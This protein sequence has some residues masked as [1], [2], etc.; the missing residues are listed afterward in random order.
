MV[1]KVL[2]SSPSQ[3]SKN[4]QRQGIPCAEVVHDT[5]AT[6]RRMATTSWHTPRCSARCSSCRPWEQRFRWSSGRP[7]RCCTAMCWSRA[8]WL[9]ETTWA[10]HA[11]LSEW[12]GTS[13]GEELSK[14]A[15]RLS[16]ACA[17]PMPQDWQIYVGCNSVAGRTQRLRAGSSQA[18]ACLYCQDEGSRRP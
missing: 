9:W 14:G 12:P 3:V 15:P 17:E 18:A 16:A 4:E 1:T 10:Q 6:C 2:S 7:L 8:C 5:G 11:C 13:A